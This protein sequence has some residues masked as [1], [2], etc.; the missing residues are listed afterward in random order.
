MLLADFGPNLH[1]SHGEDASALALTDYSL[2]QQQT[3]G[4]ET[5]LLTLGCVDRRPAQL[6]REVALLLT[7]EAALA[8]LTEEQRMKL[9]SVDWQANFRRLAG[10]NCRLRRY[11]LRSRPRR[12]ARGQCGVSSGRPAVL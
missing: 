11:P 12:S 8:T 6:A 3:L 9:L 2:L 10:K 7:D 4:Q 1:E 5:E